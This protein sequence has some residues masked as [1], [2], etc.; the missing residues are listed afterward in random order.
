MTPNAEEVCGMA[1]DDTREAGRMQERTVP[2][3]RVAKRRRAGVPKILAGYRRVSRQG[4]R[5]DERFRSPTFQRE[6]LDRWATGEGVALRHFKAEVDVSGSSAKRDVLETIIRA[7]EAGELDGIAV[8]KL[9]RLA[10]LAPRDRVE[11]FD[12]IEAAGGVVLSASENLDASTPEGRFARDVFL[13]V[14]RMQ[15]EKYAEQF[16]IAKESAVELGIAI[17][18]VAPFGYRFRTVATKTAP[19]HSLEVVAEE[20]VLVREL[21]E[22]RLAGASYGDVLAAFE[23]ATGR[24]SYRSTMRAMLEN[25]AYLGELRYGREVELV[26][27]GA[28]EAI[29]ALELFEAVQATNQARSGGRGV[30]VGKAKSLLAGIVKCEGCGRGLVRTRTGSARTY[31]YKCPNDSRH[32]SARAHI[33][34]EAL[35]AFVVDET[36]E[37]AGAI[38]ELE[39]EAV[40]EHAPDD[41]DQAELR[42]AEAEASLLAWSV[43]LAMQDRN[44]GAYA[45]G[46]QAREQRVELRRSELAALGQA[47]ELEVARSSIRQALAGEELETDEKRRLLSVAIARLVVRRLPRRGAS[48]AERV[49]L[50]FASSTPDV[51]AEDVDELLEESTTGI[52]VT[53]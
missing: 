27:A 9:D 30:A 41:R 25:R 6:L 44:A 26:N 48:V 36:I 11:L 19:V 28:H 14:A 38:A 35:E 12:R 42:L 43:D 3:E 2:G 46:L 24:S 40:V 16:A 32:C 5:A 47:S 21:F 7:I 53:H 39:V 49:G 33:G 45:A 15:W 22:L 29:V 10:R 34:A 1:S 8:A 13:G 50:D 37:W 31:A 20:A 17:K 18:S 23:Q 51:I 4:D 52:A